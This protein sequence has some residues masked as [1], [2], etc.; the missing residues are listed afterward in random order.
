MAALGVLAAR[1]ALADPGASPWIT[2]LL[3]ALA[4]SL[5]VALA[6]ATEPRTWLRRLWFALVALVYAAWMLCDDGWRTDWFWVKFSL[7]TLAEAAAVAL[8][9]ET[10]LWRWSLAPGLVLFLWLLY[11]LIPGYAND[12]V[13]R[14]ASWLV[15][16]LLLLAATAGRRAMHAEDEQL[17]RA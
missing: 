7:L 17:R 15:Q 2:G 3:P 12:V 9:A 10:R 16:A 13:Y 6:V 4:T 1:L 11:H 8:F 14:H 5:A